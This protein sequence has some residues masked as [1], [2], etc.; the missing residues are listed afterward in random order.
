[1]IV[2]DWCHCWFNMYDFARCFSKGDL[3]NKHIITSVALHQVLW[4]SKRVHASP[5]P[6][7]LS[8]QHSVQKSSVCRR[9]ENEGE[10]TCCS[11]TNETVGCRRRLWDVKREEN[12]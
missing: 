4:L 10:V 8:V 12:Y 1:M 3:D 2:Q 11:I 7:R 6:L 5:Y 9:F